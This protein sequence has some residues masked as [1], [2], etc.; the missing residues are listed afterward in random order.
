M[1]AAGKYRHVAG[2]AKQGWRAMCSGIDLT[3]AILSTMCYALRSELIPPL[4]PI[5]RQSWG[6]QCDC[7]DVAQSGMMEGIVLDLTPLYPA[8]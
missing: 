7:K 5:V 1:Y 2:R 8:I 4:E 6:R 3:L